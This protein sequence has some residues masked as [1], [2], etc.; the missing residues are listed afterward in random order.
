M[1]IYIRS[2]EEVD[3]RS[4]LSQYIN[5]K[6]WKQISSEIMPSNYY[7]LDEIQNYIEERFNVFEF[8]RKDTIGS[9]S[10]VL[11]QLPHFS[12]LV[13]SSTL[14][15]DLTSKKSGT[16]IRKIKSGLF[17][18]TLNLQE[19]EDSDYLKVS[20]YLSC[21]VFE[22]RI[23]SSEED[24][25]IDSDVSYNILSVAE[26]LYNSVDL[27]TIFEFYENWMSNFMH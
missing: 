1:K 23:W 11:V 2:N 10:P 5:R 26:K 27:N 13:V 17:S 18:S 3:D 7:V 9:Y 25:L 21:P 6:Q 16:L 22:K 12:V 4:K 8:S 24:V 14:K 20:L 15:L 19:D